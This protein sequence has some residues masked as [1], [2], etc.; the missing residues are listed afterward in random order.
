MHVHV[1]I[2]MIYYM[3]CTH[4][5]TNTNTHINIHINTHKT[6][7]QVERN[8]ETVHE[9]KVS[10]LRRNKDTVKE[11]GSGSECGILLETFTAFEPGDVLRCIKRSMI[12]RTSL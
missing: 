5:C 3:T 12:P 8:G 11:I 1:H 2:Y 7:A 4:T 9:G 10:S 6:H